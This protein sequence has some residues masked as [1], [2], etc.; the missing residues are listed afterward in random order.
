M[1]KNFVS[2]NDATEL[3]TAIGNKLETLSGAYVIRGNSTFANL[4][5]VL[6]EA[7]NGYAYNVTDAFTTDARFVEGAGKKY[8]ANSNVVVV[9]LSTYDAVT[10]VGSENPSSEGW[11]EFINGKY[12]LSTD[13]EVDG[14]KTYYAKT[15]T[16]KFDVM[17]SFIDVEA[18]ENAIQDVSDMIAGEFDDATNYTTG[19]VVVYEGGLYKFDTDHTAGA[20][21]ISEVTQTTVEELIANAEPSSLT[22]AQINAL[23]ALL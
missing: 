11:Y 3:M 21:D 5:S 22:T 13:T 10:P 7:M 15:V 12:V 9:D 18:L 20:W 6:T 19:Q 4:P 1:S 2:Y 17:G 8:P 23:L 14:T 16:V